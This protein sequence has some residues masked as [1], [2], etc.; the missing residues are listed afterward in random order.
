M[1]KSKKK[2]KLY[3]SD[4]EKH[5]LLDPSS[6]FIC[7]W[8][9]CLA[10]IKLDI[11]YT[12]T[13]YIITQQILYVFSLKMF[14]LESKIGSHRGERFVKLMWKVLWNIHQI[15]WPSMSH[16]RAQKCI[17]IVSKHKVGISKSND[18]KEIL[19][20]CNNENWSGFFFIFSR[21]STNF[22]SSYKLFFLMTNKVS[23]V[24]L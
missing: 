15:D 14:R 19:Y 16:R 8:R 9:N 1:K 22:V 7:N 11:Q 10:Q 24:I 18:R 5:I 4:E 17:Y 13:V 2:T 21:K 6:K 20:M 23:V 3:S 12:H